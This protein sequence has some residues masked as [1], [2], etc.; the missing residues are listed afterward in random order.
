MGVIF[1]PKL[2]ILHILQLSLSLICNGNFY[3]HHTLFVFG[4]DKRNKIP[5]FI[6]SKRYCI[7]CLF[8]RIS[9]V[10]I[11]SNCGACKENDARSNLAGQVFYLYDVT[12]ILLATFPR[13]ANGLSIARSSHSDDLLDRQRP[14]YLCG[15]FN[16]H[17]AFQTAYLS[18]FY[19]LCLPERRETLCGQCNSKC[20]ALNCACLCLVS[21][22]DHRYGEHLKIERSANK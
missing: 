16:T 12:T 1:N 19:P 6:F 3:W 2:I 11:S 21:K 13:R 17:S 10:W 8:D 4:D 20:I 14:P 9:A 22:L 7:N 18:H 5:V 15:H